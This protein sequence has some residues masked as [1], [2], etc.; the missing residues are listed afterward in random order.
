VFVA[1]GAP[2]IWDRLNWVRGGGSVDKKGRACVG[3]SAMWKLTSSWRWNTETVGD[4]NAHWS[5]AQALVAQREPG[6]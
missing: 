6:W 4:P 3:L 1:D 2:W 5:Q